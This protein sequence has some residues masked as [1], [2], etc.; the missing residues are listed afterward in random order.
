MALL[1]GQILINRYRIVKQL[2]RGG[3]GAIYRGWDITLEQPCAIKENLDT[4]QEAQA[5]FRRE[6]LMMSMLRHPNLP[7]V[8]DHFF[9]AGQGQYLVMDYV[10]GMN[11]DERQQSIGR[12]YQ[13]HEVVTWIDQVFDALNYLHTRQPPII[14]RDVKPANIIINGAGQAILV[15]FGI[16]KVYDRK[17][18]ATGAVAVT[19]GYSPPEQYGRGQT[20]ARSDIYALGATIYKLLTNV[21]PPNSL[22]RM[23]GKVTFHTPRQLNSQISPQAEQVILKAMAVKIN[24]RYETVAALREELLGAVTPLPVYTPLPAPS[25]MDA[26]PSPASHTSRFPVTWLLVGGVLLLGLCIF[27]VG[28]LFALWGVS[29]FLG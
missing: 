13:E 18:T 23:A 24:D 26:T 21:R 2:A 20:E 1:T 22:E 3:F 16:S 15:D 14:H 25:G 9:I 17:L 19:P 7:R 28:T 27:V 6:A 29:S 4:S 5:Q 11:L 10:E 12:P 8:T